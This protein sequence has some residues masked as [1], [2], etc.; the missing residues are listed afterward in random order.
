MK[1][2]DSVLAER[3]ELA[4]E[5]ERLQEK[6]RRWDEARRIVREA[7]ERKA[8]FFG[9]LDGWGRE[10]IALLNEEEW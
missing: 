2:L 3:D 1:T 7:A 4:A 8:I 5:V 6:A 9:A 10:L